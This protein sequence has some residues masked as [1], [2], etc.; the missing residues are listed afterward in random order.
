MDV[1][2]IRGGKKLNGT[3]QVSGAK[4]ACLPILAATL[5]TDE[6]C[7]VR[8]VPLLS[9][10]T[11]MRKILEHQGAV[12]EDL[13]GNAWKICAKNIIPATPYELVRKMRASICVMGALTG[14]LKTAEI[15]YPGGCVIGQ[16]PIDLHIKGLKKLGCEITQDAGVIR[17]DG[18][19]MRGAYIFLGGRNGST[20]TGT[21]NILMAAVLTP[22]TTQIDCA[23]CE[24]EIQDLCEMLIKMGAK[25][26]GV[27]S[28]KLTVTGVKKL[29]GC[30]HSVIPDRI[31]AGTFLLCG[32]ITGGDITVH[33]A[34]REHLGAFLDKLNEAKVPFEVI[35]ET[36]IRVRGDLMKTFVPVDIV[37]FPHPGFPT[38]L[39]AQFSALMAIT[40]GISLITERIYPNR[41]M[42]VPELGR[43]GAS[44]SIEGATAIVKGGTKLSG[45]PVMASDLRAS[46]ALVLAGLVADGETW[47]Q[48]VYHLDR[49]YEG[50]EKKL[51][52]LGAD[53]VRLD[54]SQMPRYDD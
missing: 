38:D 51:A 14:R 7:I 2:R 12:V 45:A 37:T 8:N 19:A 50:F 31:E 28:P 27:G 30:E 21:S 49:G 44:I 42:H 41:F 17:I 46:A 3:V 5:L 52:R 25:I 1:L 10:S 48:R 33:G 4:N 40:P 26:K 36:S 47:V 18:S 23:A 29:H 39:Q 24:P 22:G 54:D 16:R 9:D 20:V 43:M 11:A 6:P 35:D 13:G 34:V 15:P 53:I 32:A